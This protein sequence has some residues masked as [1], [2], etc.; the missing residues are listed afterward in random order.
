MTTSLLGKPVLDETQPWHTGVMGHL[1]TT[2]SARLMA[3]CD[4]LLIVGSELKGGIEKIREKLTHV[5]HVIEVTPDGTTEDGE[6]DA[7]GREERHLRAATAAAAASVVVIVVDVSVTTSC[8]VGRTE[9]KLTGESH[10][11]R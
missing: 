5:E 7:D 8:V 11:S 10:G 1:G 3:E 2:A 9:Q 4:T 6:P